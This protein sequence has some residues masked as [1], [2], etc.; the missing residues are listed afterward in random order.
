MADIKGSELDELVNVADDD[1]ILAIDV[2]DTT[3]AA[4]G[5]N[6]VAQKSNLLANLPDQTAAET[7]SGE[8][9]YSTFPITPSA[10]PDADYEMANKKYVDDNAGG[11]GGIKTATYVIAA[12]DSP[13]SDGADYTCDGTDDEVQIQAAIDAID[14]SGDPGIIL[15]LPGT[16]NVQSTSIN[17]KGGAPIEFIGSGRLATKLVL[18]GLSDEMFIWAEHTQSG[19][20]FKNIYFDGQDVTQICIRPQSYV[21]RQGYVRDC[22]FEG[23]HGLTIGQATNPQDLEIVNNYFNDCGAIAYV[24]NDCV[25][26]GNRYGTNARYANNNIYGILTGN[27]CIVSDN[28]IYGQYNVMGNGAIVVNDECIVA[29]N[30][31]YDTDSAIIL[32]G[33]DCIVSGNRCEDCNDGVDANQNAD[34]STISGNLF[35]GGVGIRSYAE[36]TTI[37]GNLFRDCSTGIYFYSSPYIP[38]YCEISGNG[39]HNCTTLHNLIPSTH[40]GCNLRNNTVDEPFDDIVTRVMTNNSGDTVAQG[41]VVVYDYANGEGYFTTTTTEGDPKVVGMA[42]TSITNGSDGPIQI[43]GKTTKLKVDGTN[44]I[45]TG[46]FLGTYTSAGIAKKAGAGDTAFAIAREAYNADD[47]NGVI[48]AILIEPRTA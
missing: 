6:K 38:I 43:R 48:D 1:L 39:F 41:D 24:G 44:N 42:Q 14:T 20:G 31:I 37:T 5:T 13:S 9:T 12:S 3:M 8:W 15:F 40:Y 28:I 17:V 35:H 22:W 7:I 26:S 34:Y 18:D 21:W 4:S 2:D 46:D 16:F 33:A 29:N 47:S 19:V 45:A 23:W 30:Y 25:I 27:N 10:A 32:Q 36:R 11:G